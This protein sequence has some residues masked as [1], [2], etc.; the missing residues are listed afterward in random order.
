MAASAVP[1][2]ANSDRDLAFTVVAWR[3]P[4]QSMVITRSGRAP[5][6]GFEMG[7]AAPSH[8]T[9]PK[10]PAG[11]QA[12][13]SAQSM[14]DGARRPSYLRVTFLPAQQLYGIA[15][16]WEED[17]PVGRRGAAQAALLSCSASSPSPRSTS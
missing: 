7:W 4:C 17:R 1:K 11:G 9:W 16:E 14:K 12:R 13:P 3:A 15:S 6:Q 8:T 10:V 5:S 2:H